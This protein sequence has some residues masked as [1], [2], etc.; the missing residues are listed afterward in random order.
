MNQTNF[1]DLR[2]VDLILP[3]LTI[4]VLIIAYYQLRDFR[5]HKRIEFTYD[6]YRHFFNYLNDPLNKDVRAWLFGATVEHIDK[7]KIGDLLE[8]FEAVWSLQN[9]KLVEKDVV[10]DLFSFYILKAAQAKKPSAL[11]YIEYVRVE[12][13]KV[14][15]GYSDDLFIGYQCLLN[16]MNEKK[17]LAKNNLEKTAMHRP[18]RK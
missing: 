10:Y 6:L 1:W 16:T 12:E 11:E 8:Q 3:I 13:K 17:S 4:L 5:L 7:N 14:L 18:E 2:F 9:K 15:V